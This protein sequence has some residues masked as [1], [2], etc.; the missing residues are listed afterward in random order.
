MKKLL[1][2]VFIA[3]VG[4]AS[5]KFKKT[6]NVS[7]S[8]ASLSVENMDK[9]ASKYDSL[10][11]AWKQ[12]FDFKQ[13]IAS[14][15]VQDL[16]LLRNFPYAVN[17]L[18]FMEADLHA[19]FKAAIPW[20]EKC[21]WDMF[22]ADELHLEYNDV[23]LS[24]V[25]KAFVEKVD[26]RIEELQKEMYITKND[27]RI[28]NASNIVNLFQFKEIK[29]DFMEKIA[30]NNF[31]ITGGGY[32]QLFHV[33]E[34]NAYQQMPSFITT[35]LFLQAFHIYFSYVLKSL[36]KEKFIPAV[37]ELCK[38]LYEASMAKTQDATLALM[39]EYNAVF[40]AIPYT[41]LTGKT[42]SVPAKYES[43][44]K[45]E[46][47]NATKA[48][49]TP[50]G[51]LSTDYDFPY[52]LFKPRG[53]YSRKP[54]MQAYFRA[55]MWLQVAYLCRE[56]DHQLKQ[57]IFTA[58]LLNTTKSSKN[59]PLMDVYAS[60]FEPVAFLVG[61]PDNL[62]VMDIAQFLKNE[63]INELQQALSA[64][65]V[66]RIN[67]KLVAL[68]ET[69]NLIKPKIELT[70]PDKINFMPQRYLIDN[71]V[72]L[73]M[74]DTIPNSERCFPKG[75]DVFCAFGSSSAS[76]LLNN[77]YKDNNR[78]AK[79]PEEMAR[80]QKKF[81]NYDGWNASVYNKWIES[82]LS[83][84]KTDKNYPVFMQTKAWDYKNLNTSL[85][86]WAELKHDAILYGEQPM[87]AE[88][89]GGGP[90]EPIVVGYVEPNLLFWN[91]L[92]ELI[93]LT[94]KMLSAHD[95][96]N[97][98]LKE[99][100]NSLLTYVSFLTEV[101]ELEL[102]KKTLSEAQ[103]STIEHLGSSIEWFTLSVLDPDL[104]LDNWNLVEGADRSVAVVADVFTRNIPDCNKNGVLHVATGSANNLYVVVEINGCL[105]LTRG[106]TFSYYEFVRPL[107]DR[108]TDEE[109]QKIEQDKA[110]RPPLLE[111]MQEIISDSE[112]KSDS[113]NFYSS[114][115]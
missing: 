102:A 108:L 14:L 67:Q 49:D 50:S 4:M 113:R 60:V 107:G 18:Y 92:S 47:D 24:A 44:Y 100:T 17:G 86:S 1:S 84:Q 104:R 94:S 65:N 38:K 76:D 81:D 31:V 43:A 68:T 45:T 82:L 6:E 58:S 59:V 103:Y 41:L 48:I 90:P 5:C 54:E 11:N 69:R 35:D 2:I 9:T 97:A 19:Y 101:T 80:M 83:L 106:A 28:G 23:K 37:E 30:Q 66:G 51:F 74:F 96:L 78:W 98:D 53:H 42:L 12:K 88:C 62:S 26:K 33:Y 34:E 29:P 64:E 70:C 55:M 3:V 57:C 109:W 7:D 15:S 112:P 36:E 16:R 72:L 93:T 115:C 20:Y 27:Y 25:E 32:Q 87:S 56:N 13:N 111:W 99:K 40:Y 110:K 10:R 61:L 71:E 75:L 8:K 114:G 39:A 105:R 73:N 79:Y 85:A 95:L 89:G 52:S 21:M 77:F 22:E 63:K 91:K 46:V